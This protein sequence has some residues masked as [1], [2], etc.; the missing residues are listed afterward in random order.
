LPK[1][2]SRTGFKVY[3]EADHKDGKG[4][5]IARSV[6]IQP[7]DPPQCLSF[8]CLARFVYDSLYS[9]FLAS[10]HRRRVEY[11]EAN[12]HK[13]IL[14]RYRTGE[15]APTNLLW[16]IVANIKLTCPI[17]RRIETRW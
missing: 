9:A 7:P 5:L 17:C 8:R 2:T 10:Y 4:N 1:T 15:K 6:S 13:V 11:A 14:E 16:A 12:R 3:V